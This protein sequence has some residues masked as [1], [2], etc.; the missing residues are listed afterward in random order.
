MEGNKTAFFFFFRILTRDGCNLFTTDR[1]KH[2]YMGAFP[3]FAF[4]Y[5][6]ASTITHNF[7]SERV[8]TLLEWAFMELGDGPIAVF[9]CETSVA[10]ADARIFSRAGW[11]MQDDED[12]GDT[13]SLARSV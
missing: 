5:V 6:L 3:L 10:V 8:G 13:R 9:L 1:Q 7:Q 12:V 11:W 4:A 2:D